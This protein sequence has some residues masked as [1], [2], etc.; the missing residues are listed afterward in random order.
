MEENNILK[1][2]TKSKHNEQRKNY[3]TLQWGVWKAGRPWTALPGGY[4]HGQ[5][6]WWDLK[7]W[8]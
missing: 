7:F 5:P 3:I 6:Q 8:M 4:S 1:V 2:K